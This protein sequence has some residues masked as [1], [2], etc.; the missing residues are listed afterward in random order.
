MKNVLTKIKETN[1]ERAEIFQKNIQT[2]IKN[3]VL[4]HFDDFQFY[5]G[6]SVSWSIK[7]IDSIISQEYLLYSIHVLIKFDYSY[8]TIFISGI[9]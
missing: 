4:D 7:H 9:H 6:V 2:F 5:Q 1:P 8:F 3:R